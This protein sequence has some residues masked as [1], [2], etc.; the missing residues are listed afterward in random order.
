MEMFQLEKVRFTFIVAHGQEF[1]LMA[2]RETEGVLED[3]R[4]HAWEILV[5]SVRWDVGEP[6][7]V[8]LPF[9]AHGE[10]LT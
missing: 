2:E 8:L 1:T 3:A 4:R 5:D 10:H 7:C 6:E 9:A